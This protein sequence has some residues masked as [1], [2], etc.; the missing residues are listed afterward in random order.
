M[1]N[2][3]A[4]LIGITTARFV[5]PDTGWRYNRGYEGCIKAVAQAGGLP[6]LIPVSVD[7]TVLRAIYD[8]LDGVLLPGGGDIDPVYYNAAS[9]PATYEIDKHRD[10]LEIRLARWS[11]ED[12]LPLFGIC[13]GHQVMNVA[14]G[15]TLVQDIPSEVETQFNHNV[16]DNRQTHAHDVEIAPDSRLARIIGS[17]RLGVNSVHHQSVGKAAPNTCVTAY[18]PDGVVEAMEMPERKFVLSVQ[19]HPEDLFEDDPAMMRLFTAF[20]EAAG[21]RTDR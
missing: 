4:P 2:S 3:M 21:G 13:R 5:S 7:D 17:T 15:G 6:V 19:W 16:R 12:D 11:L 18:A 1:A 14:F 10:D 9:H 20:V 8:R